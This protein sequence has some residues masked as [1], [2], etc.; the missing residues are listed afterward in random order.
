MGDHNSIEHR[1]ERS[2]DAADVLVPHHA[3][4]ADQEP[5]VELLGQRLGQRRS[6]RRVVRSV[7]E[8]RWRAAHPFQPTRAGRCGESGSHSIDVE[9]TLR[10]GA[11]ERL[12]SGQCDDGVVRLMFAVQRE[13]DIGIHPA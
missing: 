1:L 13:K 10:A 8:N 9:L 5:E 2:Q 11:E 4:H 12:D 7:D 3:D 6:S